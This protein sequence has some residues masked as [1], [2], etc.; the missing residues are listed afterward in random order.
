MP[1]EKKQAVR[2]RHA[3]IRVTHVVHAFEG[4]GLESLVG[5]MV[6][7]FDR[8]Q[9]ASS[10]ISLS[11]RI[12]RLGEALA[13]VVDHVI[14]VRPMPVVSL[15]APVSLVQALRH[16]RAEIVH[17]HSGAWFKGALA[18]RLC[19]ARGVI[20]TEH[21][22]E[23]DDP[24]F[25]RWIS[26]QASR[27]TDVVVAVSDRLEKYLRDRIDVAP[28]RL[29]TIENGVDTNRFSPA[30]ASLGRSGFD[31]PAGSLVVGS[32]GRLEPVKAYQRLIQAAAD[33]MKDPKVRQPVYVLLCGDG[34]ERPA[35]TELAGR[36]GIADRV[37]F[38]G[39]V[40][41]PVEAYRMMD[42][43]VLPSL[44]EG[45]SVS[46]IEAMASGAVP[47]VTP[48]GANRDVLGDDLAS[49]VV[50]AEDQRVF[51]AALAETLASADRRRSMA[52]AGRGIVVA[53]FSQVRMLADY[54][55]LYR[56]LSEGR[57]RET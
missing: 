24:P 35:L 14:A 23:H 38:A 27:M 53:R 40:G 3:P 44:S 8:E 15:V 4:G 37:R 41:D 20:F 46:L 50:P 17:V 5:A 13:P 42:V 45:L 48:V 51:S 28:H 1:E 36:L 34:S 19:G 21:G 2:P 26:R 55:K 33:V 16:T 47:L 39:W 12:G 57:P 52:A 25:G 56:R 29:M 31:I 30:P 43:F 7:G 10:V 6:R 22:R 54:T 9:V 32:V 18:G 11:G 49:Q